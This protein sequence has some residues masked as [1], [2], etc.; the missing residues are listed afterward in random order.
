MTDDDDDREELAFRVGL[1]LAGVIEATAEHEDRERCARL[2]LASLGDPPRNPRGWMLRAARK[3]LACI[4]AG[5][6]GPA[7]WNNDGVRWLAD[8]AAWAALCADGDRAG[9]ALM[10]RHDAI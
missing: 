3:A 1:H 6:P 9:E 7:K 5:P 8:A 4:N 2:V 10:A